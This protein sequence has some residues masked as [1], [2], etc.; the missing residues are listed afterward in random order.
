MTYF[1]YSVTSCG[2]GKAVGY[3]EY[4]T[5][6]GHHAKRTDLLHT[7]YGNL[8]DWAASPRDLWTAADKYERKN[9]VSLRQI[10]VS[11]PNIQTQSENISLAR[12]IVSALAG[13]KP[14][15]MALHVPRS[16]I[17]NEPN[18]HVH[19]AICDRVP[20][21]IPRPPALMFRRHN[22]KCPEKGGRRKDSGG[23]T[24][25]EL[26]RRVVNDRSRVAEITN[27]ALA[28]NG[29]RERVDSRSLKQQGL[30]RMPERYLGPA[31]IRAMTSEEKR[32]LVAGRIKDS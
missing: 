4:V 11:L 7:E 28:K 19:I 5:R 30:A 14:F 24:P 3:M 23:L 21:G 17:A 12:E 6:Q 13:D 16:A 20:D 32:S 1:R 22:P 10:T 8:P 27:T 25:S 9:G 18:P 31:R 29:Y 15:Q 26:G 2:K